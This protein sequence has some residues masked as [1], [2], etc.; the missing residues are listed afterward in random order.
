GHLV[1]DL[2]DLDLVEHPDQL[3][4]RLVVEMRNA[5]AGAPARER[6]EEGDLLGE[7]K[8]AQNSREVGRMRGLE[9]R[10][11]MGVGLR[12]GDGSRR[13]E[14]PVLVLI[15]HGHRVRQPPGAAAIQS[16]ARGPSALQGRTSS[17]L[18]GRLT[19]STIFIAITAPRRRAPEST[20][21]RSGA[22]RTR[23]P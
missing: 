14:Q 2:R 23:A 8:L 15:A 12:P 22:S 13:L 3:E 7:R 6:A 1:E 21:A 4:Q 9:Q 17:S 11:L 20:R 10:L 18:N 19:G 5:L 16:A